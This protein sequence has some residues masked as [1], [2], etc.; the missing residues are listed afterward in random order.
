F[1]LPGTIEEGVQFTSN[2]DVPP[3]ETFSW[4]E[5]G[6]GGIRAGRLWFLCTRRIPDI[7]GFHNG[8]QWFSD[9]FREQLTK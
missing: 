7:V 3:D 2:P 1:L 9:G 4:R 5:R 6:D 8:M